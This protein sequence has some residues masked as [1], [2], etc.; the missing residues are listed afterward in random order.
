M[1]RGCVWGLCIGETTRETWRQWLG[2]PSVTDEFD[3]EKAELYRK[4]VPDDKNKAGSSDEPEAADA[5]ASLPSDDDAPAVP[6]DGADAVPD[7]G[8]PPLDFNE[9]KIV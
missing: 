8:A 1:D 2:E 5:S 4:A 6:D 3:A 7:D 9:A